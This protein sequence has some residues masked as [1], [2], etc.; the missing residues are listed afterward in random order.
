MVD[1]WNVCPYCGRPVHRV[2]EKIAKPSMVQEPSIEREAII[3]TPPSQVSLLKMEEVKRRRL[4]RAQIAAIIVG[5]IVTL[6]AIIIPVVSISVYNYIHLRKTVQFYVNNGMYSASYTVK[7]TRSTLNSYRDRYHPS[8]FS[9]DPNETAAII[10]SYCTPDDEKIVKIAQG[11]KSKCTD[12]YDS[13]E[14]INALLSFTQAIGYEYDVMD[15]AQYPLETIFDQG[16]CEDLSILFGS[17]VE[18]VG[19]DAIIIILEVY[20]ESEGAWFAHACV[21]VYLSFVPTAHW[22][23]PPSYYFDVFENDNE[24]WIC[25]T[26]DQGWMIGE[27]PTSDPMYYLMTGYAFID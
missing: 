6:A 14:V 27:L 7:T 21:G 9:W 23:Y 12:Q 15:L 25:E 1:E 3:K 17:L 22:S 2:P 4:T 10:E 5:T 26:T 18:A 24:Y 8:H 13:E 19:Y 16:D 11:V 20:D